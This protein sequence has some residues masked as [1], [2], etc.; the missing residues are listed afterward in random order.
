[1]I[2]FFNGC[3][4]F[5]QPQALENVPTV[6]IHYLKYELIKM[7]K[8]LHQNCL[9]N[10]KDSFVLGLKTKKGQILSLL[11]PLWEDRNAVF[12]FTGI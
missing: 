9:N 10:N 12:L 2:S 8:E 11:H 7:I 5:P 3:A 6:I 1:M 4:L